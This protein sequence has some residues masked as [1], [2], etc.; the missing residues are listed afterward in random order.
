MEVVKR[1]VELKRGG[2]ASW[3]GLCPFH[4]EK[5]PSFH[6]HETRQFFHCFG[7]GAKGDVFSFLVQIE[8]R[9]FMEVL[10]DLARDGGIE[11]PEKQLSPAERKAQEDAESDRARMHRVME[12]AVSF[13][14][15]QL[16]APTGGA[17]RGY[18]EGR[19]ISPATQQKFRLGYAPARS[20]AMSGFLAKA[21]VS[22][23]IAER[24]G[25]V[26]VSERGRY[27]FFRDRV[28]L[29]VIDRQKRV[30]GFSSRLLDPEAKERKY[31]N[32]PDSPLFHKKDVLYGIHSALD[33]I[34]KGGTAVVVEGNF[35]VLALHEAGITE[36]VAPMGTALTFE[37]IE[38]LGRVAQRVVVVFDGDSAGE[39]AA[40]R[41][42]PLFLDADVDG[43]IARMPAGMDPDDFIRKE[44]ADAFRK[45]VAGAKPMMEEAIDA[46]SREIDPTGPGQ[47]AALEAA[48]EL[49]AKV[50]NRTL[51]EIYE[52]R[53]AVAF[54]LT[55]RQVQA[56]VR[57]AMNN[58]A[59][60]A[61]RK[62][63]PTAAPGDQPVR[64]FTRIPASVELE[65]L[66]ILVSRPE[67]ASLPEARRAYDLLV[68]ESLRPLYRSALESIQTMASGKLD[69][70]A[71]LE[72]GPADVRDVVARALME[73]KYQEGD[74]AGRAMRDVVRKLERTR[75]EYE[76][77]SISERQRAAAARG[78]E[79]EA[80]A[81]RLR[82]FE[83]I[84]TKQGLS[85][86][87]LRP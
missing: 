38:T 8:Q 80:R 21:G 64:V 9:T 78:D 26:G 60:A 7:C 35:D 68:D 56:A 58:F 24:L 50:R 84:R 71:W 30:V 29:P 69:V 47:V 34:R 27:D 16:Q 63:V 44:G 5:T 52:G 25:L 75:L 12:L 57:A 85:D 6:V 37:Q 59:G 55:P 48:A 23:D 45:L 86:T 28:M 54:R 67:L 43:R 3:K 13:F 14:E 2:T 62:P 17:A 66:V 81:L 41:V 77:K 31:V 73:G 20:D 42:L 1:H 4:S 61:A 76:L 49:L 74:G 51:R 22:P 79:A 87:P 10:R 11:L 53:A 83:L 70:S 32:S 36:S 15:A 39:R 19:S 18:I 33:A 65:A 46:L 82:E 72:A 40:R